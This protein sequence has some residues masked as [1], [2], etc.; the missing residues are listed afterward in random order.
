MKIVIWTLIIILVIA[1]IGILPGIRIN[2]QGV[3]ESSAVDYIRMAMYFI[4]TGTCVAILSI[5]LGLWVFRIVIALVKTIWDM[6][7]V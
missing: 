2:S 5:I 7:P 6:L 1:L 3:L 4:P